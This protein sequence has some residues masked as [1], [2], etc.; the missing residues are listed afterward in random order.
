MKSSP[1]EAEM[2]SASRSMRKGASFRDTTAEIPA[3]STTRR[4]R[5]CKSLL[6]I[7]SLRVV[8]SAG[9]SAVVSRKDAPFRIDLDAERISASFGEDFIAFRLGVIPPDMLSQRMD[10]HFVDA[11]AFHMPADSAPLGGVQPAVGPKPQA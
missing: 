6:Q 9:I 10:G 2:R 5:I 1:K 7:R 3:D 11:G 4:E 8:E